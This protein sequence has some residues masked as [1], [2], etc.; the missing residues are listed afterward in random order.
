MIKILAQTF[1]VVDDKNKFN[2]R[3]KSI[4]VS[5]EEKKQRRGRILEAL[6]K[7]NA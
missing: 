4:K 7:Y 6:F 1:A 3:I 2:V 5:E